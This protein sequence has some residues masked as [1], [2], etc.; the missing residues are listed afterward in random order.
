MFQ[1]SRV[2]EQSVALLAGVST[3]HFHS[4]TGASVESIAD[5]SNFLSYSHQFVV[6]WEGLRAVV[7]MLRWV[8]RFRSGWPSS[9]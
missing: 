8:P 5:L 2:P 1:K 7:V 4:I 6:L 9:R 3:L